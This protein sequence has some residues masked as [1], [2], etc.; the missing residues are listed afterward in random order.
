MMQCTMQRI[1][2]AIDGSTDFVIVLDWILDW[3]KP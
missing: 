3:G 2:A 1:M